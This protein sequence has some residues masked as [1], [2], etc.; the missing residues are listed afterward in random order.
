MTP[1]RTTGAEVWRGS[2]RI[3]LPPRPIMTLGK[4]MAQTGHA[5]MIAAA[6]LA[7]DQ[8]RL[9][10]WIEAGLPAL[11]GRAD[12]GRWSELTGGMADNAHAWTTDGL[13]LVRDAGF[14]EVAPGTITAI[15]RVDW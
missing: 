3:W 10:A 7:G 4:A 1:R 9:R 5:G 8:P 2:L 6:L 12:T 15:A 11:A 13:L 14:T